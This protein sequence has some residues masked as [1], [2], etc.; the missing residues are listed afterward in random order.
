MN[1]YGAVLT[2]HALKT[3]KIRTRSSFRMVP[4]AE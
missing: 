1:V 4:A 2:E 3:E